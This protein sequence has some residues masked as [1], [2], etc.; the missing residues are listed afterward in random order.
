MSSSGLISATVTA[1][2]PADNAP[3][4]KHR[5]HHWFQY[6]EALPVPSFILLF[7][8]LGAN[9]I[10]SLP[11]KS[12]YGY[13]FTVD[14]GDGVIDEIN[15]WDDPKKNHTY[16][17]AG[18]HTVTIDGRLEAWQYPQL[19]IA[20]TIYQTKIELS[21]GVVAQASTIYPQLLEVQ[22]WGIVGFRFLQGAFRGCTNLTITATDSPDLRTV[23]SL[24]MMFQDSGVTGNFA[25]WDTSTITNMISMFYNVPAFNSNI[26][27]WDVSNVQHFSIMF[28]NDV[29]FNQD[30]TNWDMSSASGLGWMFYNC[31]DFSAG[32]LGGWTTSSFTQ[33]NYMF[34]GC[35]V[36]NHDLSLWEM[37]NVNTTFEMF[38]HGIFNQDIS[39]WD[40]TSVT[41]AGFMFVGNAVF[42]Q[43]IGA[44]DTS[45]IQDYDG[46]FS[47][48]ESF[49]QDISNWDV[50][51]AVTMG[52]M[53]NQP[54]FSTANYDLLLNAWSQQALKPN[55]PLWVT[56]TKYS[57]S[58]QPARDVLTN[59]PNNWQVIDD[60]VV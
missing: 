42:N 21:G 16:I 59:P 4:T 11:L 37:G 6:G 49:N 19:S 46:M 32:D 5:G 45:N 3:T 58:S 35:D 55:V 36:F 52:G 33:C 10:V 30:L 54:V 41:D 60:G 24:A 50:S 22:Q 47:G 53:I 2:A 56:E 28:A 23:T 40:M 48:A 8:T 39:G 27:A 34:Y 14:W 13:Q 26:S 18:Q 1:S 7:E 9:E 12:G 17:S 20:K 38:A 29:L 43:P 15:T 44:W 31:H 51:N 25:D 57:A